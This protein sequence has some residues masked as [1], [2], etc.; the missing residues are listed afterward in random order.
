MNEQSEQSQECEFCHTSLSNAPIFQLTG[1]G[2]QNQAI[3]GTCCYG[4]LMTPYGYWID[5]E[6]IDKNS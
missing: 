1:A 6:R 3:T 5:A 2:D 4:K